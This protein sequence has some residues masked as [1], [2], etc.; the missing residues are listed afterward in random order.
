M[1][2]KREVRQD[3]SKMCKSP[4]N[5]RKNCVL[6]NFDVILLADDTILM[7]Y[8]NVAS[9]SRVL[10]SRQ[11]LSRR[12][13]DIEAAWLAFWRHGEREGGIS[14]HRWRPTTG[15]VINM[16]SCRIISSIVHR[17]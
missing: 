10:D 16:Y 11:K 1:T 14:I 4:L 8:A 6:S 7:I 13:L 3:K 12:E 2:S 17:M 15:I 5:F 9:R